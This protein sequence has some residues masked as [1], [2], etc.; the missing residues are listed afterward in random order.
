MKT[1]K[2]AQ[3]GGKE[4]SRLGFGCMRLPL[5][6]DGT[7]NRTLAAEMLD[8]AYNSG[9]NYFDTA[10]GY[11]NGESE[12]FVGEALKKYP[13]DKI[14]IATK[15]PMS[16]IHEEVQVEEIFNKQLEK[17][18]MEY[19]DFYMLHGMNGMH[20]PKMKNFD[21]YSKMKAKKD[22]GIIKQLGFSFHGDY[23]T[24][25]ELVDNYEWDFVQIQINYLDYIMI[26]S[27]ELYDKLCEKNIPVIVMEPVRGGFLANP[28]EE[29]AAK[30]SS[31]E[32]GAVSP[33]AWAMRWCIHMENMPVILSGMTTMEQVKDN[34]NTFSV[35]D[36]LTT[37]Q[38]ALLEEC[39]DIVMQAKSVPCTGCRYCMDC[40]SGVD[41][42]KI[43][44]IY[45][46]YQ[47]FKNA[48]RANNNYNVILSASGHGSEQ[49]IF[50]GICVPLCPQGIDIPA[51]LAA[52]HE[53]L[54]PLAE[55]FK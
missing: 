20:L 9:V 43:F 7:I 39:R 37:A 36:K 21:V 10:F 4:V 54:S 26:D 32:G 13:R 52:A 38:I 41:I 47:L 23:A 46:E 44:S 2:V 30:M 16:Q 8:E 12:L 31:F 40:P 14:S 17:T 1:T 29:V 49:C 24:L 35:A 25:C 18:Q 6:E 22:A 33:A 50:C 27:K 48:F 55:R 19:F 42:P 15:L 34:I 3:W 11:H 28:P 5:N 51:E 53:V 45:N